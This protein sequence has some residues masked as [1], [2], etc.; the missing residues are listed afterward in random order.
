MAG[1]YRVLLYAYGY[2]LP[3]LA[4]GQHQFFR[5][6]GFYTKQCGG[7][8]YEV[9]PLGDSSV[10]GMGGHIQFSGIVTGGVRHKGIRDF[11]TKTYRNSGLSHPLAA[12]HIQAERTAETVYP[13][14]FLGK[15]EA[16]PRAGICEPAVAAV[17]GI[18]SVGNI[19]YIIEC[20][21]LLRS[22][23]VAGSAGGDACNQQSNTNNVYKLMSHDLIYN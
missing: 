4:A 12:E 1:Y 5:F 16:H 21:P 23:F 14:L 22:V 20:I 15:S 8:I 10:T 3:P 2:I 7:G 19:Q 18:G 13:V 9:K 17:Q 11:L 6:V